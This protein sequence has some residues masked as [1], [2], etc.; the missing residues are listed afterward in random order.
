LNFACDGWKLSPRCSATTGVHWRRR[1]GGLYRPDARLF[2]RHGRESKRTVCG[3][4]RGRRSI[5][6]PNTNTG[7]RIGRGCLFGDEA[8]RRQRR[9]CFAS[10]EICFSLRLTSSESGF[11][12]RHGIPWPPGEQHVFRRAL[13][14]QR[15]ADPLGAPLHANHPAGR[16]VAAASL[17]NATDVA[18]W[19]LS[20]HPTVLA[21]AKAAASRQAVSDHVC[22]NRG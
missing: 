20:R 3:G 12:C 4:D 19:V 11:P 8:E 18:T 2:R 16:L 14:R 17:F 21:K 22:G 15:T 13:S 6:R 10:K 5:G 9:S 7:I 1:R